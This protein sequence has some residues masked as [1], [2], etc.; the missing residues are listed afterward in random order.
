MVANIGPASYNYDESLA[1]LRFASRAKD[2]KNKPRINEDPKDALLREF[3]EEIARLKASLAKRGDTGKKG[4]KKRHRST[5]DDEERESSVEEEDTTE[6][7]FVEQRA[8]LEKEKE[9]ILLNQS[10]IAEEREKLLEEVK[11]KN[12]EIVRKM[13]EQRTLRD[14]I[15]QM[16]SKLLS[17]GTNIVDHTNEQQVALEIKKQEIAQQKVPIIPDRLR[18]EPVN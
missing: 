11:L 2:I 16:E 1:T 15:N 13:E 18:P 3:Q 6:S 9:S 8:V 10:L 14:R 12:V 7:G 5:K 4:K 17:G